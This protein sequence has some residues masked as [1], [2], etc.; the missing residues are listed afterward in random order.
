MH[1]NYGSEEFQGYSISFSGQGARFYQEI[2]MPIFEFTCEQC[3]K[4]FEELVRSS[5]SVDGVVCPKCGSTQIKRKIS[6]FA[7]K[8]SGG[9]SFTMSSSA[10][11]CSTGST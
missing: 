2:Y 6:T 1:L 3:D 8:I 11:S 5:N 4:P 10:P 7:S 9:S